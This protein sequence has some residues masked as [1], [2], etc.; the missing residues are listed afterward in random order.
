MSDATGKKSLLEHLHLGD[1]YERKARLAPALLS[2]VFLLPAAMAYGIPL[3]GWLN[4][5]LAGSGFCIAIAIGLSYLASAMGNRMQTKI[6]PNWPHD[7]PTN[8]WLRPDNGD[9]S[10]QQKEL[11][12]EAVKQITSLDLQELDS[13]DPE[14]RLRINDAVRQVRAQLRSSPSYP[15]VQRDNE[16]YGFVRNFTGL[17]PVWFGFSCLSFLATWIAVFLIEAEIVWAVVASI[18][19]IACL[20]LAFCVMI[21][22]T[23]QRANQYAQSFFS[24]LVSLADSSK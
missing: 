8:S 21:P 19:L 10:K 5:L 9:C 7:S 12:W 17:R 6:W 2:V 20:F 4:A 18:L 3:S 22:F 24:A 1:N 23:K 15:L 13:S 16:D 14:L 11:W